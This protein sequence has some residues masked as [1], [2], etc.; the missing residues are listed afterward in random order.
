M[1]RFALLAVGAGERG[2]AN[3]LARRIARPVV[4][5]QGGVARLA[6]DAVI[7]RR[8]RVAATVAGEA[9]SAAFA[10]AR[11][12]ASAVS[13][14]GGLGTAEQAGRITVV[15][16]RTLVAMGSRK[17]GETGTAAIVGD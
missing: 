3:T 8:T 4:I 16:V 13:A 10:A 14:A 5:A 15:I 17:P 7:S 2:L 12:R 6:I 1:P 9:L 11:S